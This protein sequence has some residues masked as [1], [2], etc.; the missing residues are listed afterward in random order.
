MCPRPTISIRPSLARRSL[1]WKN[2]MRLAV[3]LQQRDG[4]LAALDRPVE[5][6]LEGHVLLGRVGHDDVVG[7]APVVD[8][9]EL[10]VVVVEDQRLAR[11]ARLRA[12]RVE[13]LRVRD[14][15]GLGVQLVV[16]RRARAEVL[17]AEDLVVGDD[18]V[19]VL[20]GGRVADVDV[21]TGRL[22]AVLAQQVL[23]RLRG[24]AAERERLDVL[25]AVGAQLAEDLFGARDRG[26]VGAEPDVLGERPE[27]DV[28]LLRGDAAAA[29]AL[30]ACL[31]RAVSATPAL[32]PMA[33]AAATRPRVNDCFM[34]SC[35]PRLGDEKTDPVSSA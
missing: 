30:L 17:D 1:T 9:R 32:K 5:V 2:W 20:R 13:V 26:G 24:Q 8:L 3:A 6:E 33:S 18:L 28:D 14:P 4:V 16:G 10:P 21:A 25:V 27:L 31:A 23:V 7:R 22:Q 19:D 35:L 34:E 12:R 11:L 15:V 29:M